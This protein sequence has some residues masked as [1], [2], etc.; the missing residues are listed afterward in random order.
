LQLGEQTFGVDRLLGRDHNHQA[1]E[2]E[3]I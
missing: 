3:L 2:R 1:L